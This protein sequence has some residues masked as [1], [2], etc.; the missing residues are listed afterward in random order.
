MDFY[1]RAPRRVVTMA[2]PEV[3][4]ESDLEKENRVLERRLRRI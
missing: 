3:V 2:D 4:P 1:E